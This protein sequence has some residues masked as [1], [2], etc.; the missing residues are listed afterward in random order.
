MPTPVLFPGMGDVLCNISLGQSSACVSQ[1]ARVHYN[2]YRSPSG[3]L[4]RRPCLFV[5]H[6]DKKRIGRAA[7]NPNRGVDQD[8]PAV[9]NLA[10]R[11]SKHTQCGAGIRLVGPYANFA[12]QCSIYDTPHTHSTRTATHYPNHQ[13][14]FVKKNKTSG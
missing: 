5:T 11:R 1:G 10:H 6:V 4:A 12:F 2:E 7:P 8:T 14:F 13:F 9:I 3:G